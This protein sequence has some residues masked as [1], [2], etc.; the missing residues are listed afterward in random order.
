MNEK[1]AMAAAWAVGVVLG[2]IFYGGLWWTVRKGLSSSRPALWFLGSLLGRT[3]VVLLG[4]Y[5]V[6]GGDW[7]RLVASLLG[8]V[9]AHA[10]VGLLVRPEEERRAAPA[11]G[12]SDAP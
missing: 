3:S 1:L 11:R 5:L 10:A 12:A 4:V 8:F 7:K 9:T 6:S 2:A